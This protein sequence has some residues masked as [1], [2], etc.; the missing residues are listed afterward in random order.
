MLE[1]YECEKKLLEESLS[2][3]ASAMSSKESSSSKE[4][5]VEDRRNITDE[6][7]EKMAKN[8]SENVAT[9]KPFLETVFSAL[10]CSENDYAA[11]FALCLLYAMANNQGK[12]NF[13][14]DN[15]QYKNV[16]IRIEEF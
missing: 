4:M 14:T 16:K 15:S 7:K 10:D 9:E 6:E 3:E 1:H 11:L 12:L 2:D 8:P 5:L 13:C